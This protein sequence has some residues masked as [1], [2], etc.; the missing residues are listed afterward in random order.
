M[1]SR[2]FT[3]NSLT[4]HHSHHST[5]LCYSQSNNEDPTQEPQSKPQPKP[6][7]KPQS[8]CRVC[9][10]CFSGES[11]DQEEEEEEELL[12]LE[13]LHLQGS[14]AGAPGDG[15]FSQGDAHDGGSGGRRT[16][17]RVWTAERTARAWSFEDDNCLGCSIRCTLGLPRRVVQACHFRDGKGNDQVLCLKVSD[18]SL[19]PPHCANEYSSA[20]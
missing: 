3:H 6:R 18:P 7:S 9:W 13:W 19:S 16:G 12:S 11:T 5:R 17:P 1:V 8:P 10:R 2:T 15:D 20:T 14:Q 4:T